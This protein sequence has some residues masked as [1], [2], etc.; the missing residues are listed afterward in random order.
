MDL[1]NLAASSLY[2]TVQ[3]G[4]TALRNISGEKSDAAKGRAPGP[5]F[6]GEAD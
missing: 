5:V 2:S 1:T 3:V 6:N 4:I